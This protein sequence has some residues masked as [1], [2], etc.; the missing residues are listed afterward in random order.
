MESING[1]PV[2]LSAV[3]GSINSVPRVIGPYTSYNIARD[4]QTETR[5]IRNPKMTSNNQMTEIV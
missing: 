2:V 5:A 1:K 3:N 4:P